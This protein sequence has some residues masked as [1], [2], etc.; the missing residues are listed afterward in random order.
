MTDNAQLATLFKN[1]FSTVVEGKLRNHFGLVVPSECT[2]SRACVERSMFVAPVVAGDVKAIIKSLPN[3][4]AVGY[5]DI[6]TNF[7]KQTSDLLSEGIARLFNA[8]VMSGQFPDLLKTGLITPVPK[9]GDTHNL[10]NYRPITIL[11]VISK[12]MEKLMVDKINCF[13]QKHNIPWVAFSMA[14]GWDIRQKLLLST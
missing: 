6:S 3:K 11:S 12:I 9:K 7:I 5:D 1:Q 4:G 10:A 2:V 13:V 14:S 8:S